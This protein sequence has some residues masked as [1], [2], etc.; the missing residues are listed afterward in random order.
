MRAF[1]LGLFIALTLVA[2]PALAQRNCVK[3]SPVVT[4]ALPRIRHA[5]QRRPRRRVPQRAQNGP[6]RQDLLLFLRG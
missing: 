4:L 2:N 5:E 3:G 1:A 6:P